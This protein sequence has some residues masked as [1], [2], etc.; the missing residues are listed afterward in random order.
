MF[1]TWELGAVSAHING[2]QKD[3]LAYFIHDSAPKV[4]IY[5]GDMHPVIEARRRHRR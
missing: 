1:G 4:L 2:L 5:T 3:N